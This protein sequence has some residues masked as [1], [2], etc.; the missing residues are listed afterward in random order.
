MGHIALFV[1]SHSIICPALR[2][3]TFGMHAGKRY[4]QAMLPIYC[5]I[6]GLVHMLAG[7]FQSNCPNPCM[8]GLDTT[9]DESRI[10]KYQSVFK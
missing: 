3:L 2:K 9:V 6:S 1:L 7:L 10:T 5:M 4:M 8:D